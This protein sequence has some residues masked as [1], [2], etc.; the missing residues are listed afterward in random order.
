MA[1]RRGESGI[2][3][4]AAATA[5]AL[6][7]VAACGGDSGSS[8]TSSATSTSVPGSSTSTQAGPTTQP[9]TTIGGTGTTAETPDTLPPVIAEVAFAF[10]AG[11]DPRMLVEVEVGE[12]PD[13]PWS[14]AGFDVIPTLSG[15]RFWVRF[16]VT[17]VDELGAVLTELDISGIDAGSYLGEDICALDSPLPL[18]G[19]TTCVV[20]G[21]DGFPVQSGTRQN[22]FTAS[23][24]GDRQGAPNRWFDPQ[25][26]T[27]LG[28]QGS[29]N[30]FHLVFD[31]ADGL[32]VD[33]WADASEVVIEIGG[34]ELSRPV[35]VDCSDHFPGG[36]SATGG[37]PT[38][39]EPALAAYVIESYSAAGERTAG[40]SFVPIEQLPFTPVGGNEDAFLYEGVVGD[41]TTTS[42]SG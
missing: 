32:R 10:A 12:S 36:R 13:G 16:T 9:S 2:H 5:I 33:G 24:L 26:P 38:P 42:S 37:S 8:T 39:G 21:A 27:A 7:F 20:G 22:D 41:T 40:C 3:H 34:L 4:S 31:T 29:R 14:P 18:D 28:Y 19:Q 11:D 35:K 23:G 15:P 6:L 1:N 30:S 17:N 25:I